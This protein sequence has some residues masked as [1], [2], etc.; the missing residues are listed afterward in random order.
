MQTDKLKSVSYYI[1]Y[2][3]QGYQDW[4]QYFKQWKYFVSYDGSPWKEISHSKWLELMNTGK[5]KTIFKYAKLK[6]TKVSEKEF[7]KIRAKEEKMSPTE[8][9]GFNNAS[10]K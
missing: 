3:T 9:P 2:Y 10:K 4:S 5:F 1:E 7:A 8:K 6:S